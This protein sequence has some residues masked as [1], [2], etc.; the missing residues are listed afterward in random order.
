M[1]DEKKRVGRP[2]WIPPDP[3]KVESLAARGLTMEQIASCLGIHYA[4]LAE[5]RKEFVEFDE[6]IKRGRDKGISIIANSLYESAKEGNTTAQIFFLKARA[7]W[8]EHYDQ[9]HNH[10]LRIEVKEREAE[11]LDELNKQYEPKK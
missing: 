9:Y 2:P 6:A 11:Y 5:K 1:N 10:N 7:K 8:S 4:T 3:E